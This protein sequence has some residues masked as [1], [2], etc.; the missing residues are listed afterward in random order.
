M[1]SDLN[2]LEVNGLS[3][4]IHH[5]TKDVH[6]GTTLA[7]CHSWPVYRVVDFD[8]DNALPQNWERG[9]VNKTAGFVGVSS[10]R[11]LWFD[12][13]AN[14][15]HTHDV[16]VV[17]SIQGM[18]ALTGKPIEVTRL[19]QYQNVCP[20]HEE[21]FGEGRFC[22]VCGHTWPNQ[23]YIA[24]PAQGGN[25]W[26]DGW[27]TLDGAIR[28]FVFSEAGEGRGVAEQVMGAS[29][30][31][32]IGFA[33]YLSVNPKP[34]IPSGQR[35]RGGGGFESK[36]IGSSSPFGDPDVKLLGAFY[37]DADDTD[38][39]LLSAADDLETD[40][41]ADDAE[42]ESFGMLADNAPK[43]LV[44]IPATSRGA[45]A[46]VKTEVSF[47]RAVDQAFERDPNSLEHWQKTAA[48]LIVLNHANHAWVAELT[49]NGPT[50]DRTA[51]GMGPLAGLRGA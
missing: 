40:F 19:E 36:A 9:D 44:G 31:H 15:Q 30:S 39:H 27:R 1:R 8:R 22:K 26:I 47:G 10:D 33:F 2:T 35:R 45:S 7:P 25:F 29:R 28:Q 41:G 51:G 4:G 32:A 43:H 13:N 24:G 37:D 6:R 23:N 46:P 16:A 38:L 49:K 21:P 48:G 42:P 50:V 5:P 20:I 34:V 17:V 18:N 3:I 14:H 11:E 12:F